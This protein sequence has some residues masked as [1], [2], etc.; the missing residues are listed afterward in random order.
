MWMAMLMHASLAPLLGGGAEPDYLREVKP[1]LA[2]KC[3]ACHGALQQKADLRLDTVAAMREG[4]VHGPAL[5]PGKSGASLLL[6]HV[7]ERKG[8]RRMPPPSDGEALS[9]PQ[10]A[11]LRG[12]ID[13]G[14]PGPADEKPEADPR[15]HWA[16]R[17]PMRPAVPMAGT[18]NPIDAFLADAWSKRGLKPQPAADRRLLVRRLY[19]DFVGVPPTLDEQ[20]AFLADASPNA[21]EKLVDHLLASPRYGQRWARHW[22][23][24]WRYSD[25][26]GLGAD[27]R[28]SQKHLWHWRDWIVESLNS[29]KGYDQ[30]LREMLA[31]DELHPNDLDRL[32]A[33]GFLARQYFKFNRTTWLDETVE[34]TSKAFLGLTI[35]CAKCHDH[36]YDPIRQ[37][38]YYRMRAFFEPYQIRTEQAASEVDFDKD[39]IVR[40]YDAHPETPTY[41]LVR[42]DDRNPAKDRPLAP[43]VPQL[44]LWKPLDIQPVS[45]PVEAQAPG[46]R[47]NVLAN[48]LRSAQQKIDAARLALAKAK[49]DAPNLVAAAEKALLAAEAQPD[50]LKARVAAERARLTKDPKAAELARA[51]A[52]GEKNIA[53]LQAEETLARTIAESLARNAKRPEVEKKLAAATGAVAAAR[54]AL[55]S[56]GDEFTPIQG[57]RKTPESPTD[58]NAAKVVSFPAT[59][60]GRRTALADWIADPKNPLT[61][62][63]AVNHVWTRHFGKPLV[64][65]V[66]DFGRKGAAPSHPELLD[67]LAV[68]FMENGWSMKHLHR[69]IATSQF[70]RMSSSAL[71]ADPKTLAG[72][73]DNRFLWRRES[74]RMEAQAL[75][76]SLLHLGGE[77][78]FAIGGPSIPIAEE[79]RRRS[80]YFVHSSIDNQKFLSIF[81]DAAVREC[82]RR[83]ESIVP[84]QALAL[85]N[86]KLTLT[87]AGKINDALYARLGDKAGDAEFIRAAFET[88][89][90]VTPT[91]DEVAAC[92]AALD[93]W[94]SRAVGRGD[95]VRH[96][97]GNLVHALL[98]HNDFVTVR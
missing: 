90:A 9:A 6:D 53:L 37:A 21:V 79:S 20:E 86:S 57:A 14:A 47:P 16:F 28:N 35:A 13:R 75:R 59:S 36:K 49:A 92:R 33:T 51:A 87:S 1:I 45:L 3:F 44:L 48:H 67:F 78:D 40:V 23:D 63:V 65:T 70:Y 61:A 30:F 50:V 12:W 26:W 15:D 39:G 41:L 32:R 91:K 76:D 4:G 89:L 54:K 77:L 60:T 98:N 93:E 31:A 52:R 27:V 97:R 10:I 94:R 84:Q 18:P 62:R 2:E 71:D 73:P 88:I 43:G 5:V 64:G 42:G 56:P 96:S 74:V 46:L 81:D 34:H 85:A 7:L 11:K 69:L 22:M 58:P 8:H 38:D 80:L 19:V 68:E 66:F 55:E 24:V 25:Q 29:D 83:S 72:D 95:A 82:Y 17:A